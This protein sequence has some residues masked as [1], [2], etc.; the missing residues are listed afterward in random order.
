MA[1]MIGISLDIET[2]CTGIPYWCMDTTSAPAEGL[3]IFQN[4]TGWDGTIPE[5]VTLLFYRTVHR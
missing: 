4:G 2:L 3:P 1:I 5:I